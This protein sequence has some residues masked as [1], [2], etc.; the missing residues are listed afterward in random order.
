M[1]TL[2]NISLLLTA[3]IILISCD[4]VDAPRLP[5]ITDNNQPQKLK[6]ANSTAE[7]E[8]KIKSS[9]KT[10]YGQ[11]VESQYFLAS[12]E[13]SQS[14]AVS[15]STNIQEN[16]ID[17]ADRLKTDGNYLYFSKVNGAGI[18][19]IKANEKSTPLVSTLKINTLNNSILSGLYLLNDPKQLI[20]I[21]GDGQ[22]GASVWSNWFEPSYWQNRTTELFSIDVSDPL[23]PQQT[24][25]L[26]VDGQLISSRRIDN[27]LY[28]AT[29]Y[30]PHIDGLVNYPADASEVASN[31]QLIDASSLDSLLPQYR[32]NNQ[33][34]QPLF[35]AS[36]CFVT[37]TETSA[38]QQ[39]S[40]ISLLAIDLHN[41]Q[42]KPTGQCFSGDT[43]TV[44]ASSEA[45]YLATT[46]YSYSDNGNGLVYDGKP[47]T[48]IHKFSLADTTP[49]Y[50]GSGSVEGHLGWQQDLKAFRMSEHENVLRVITYVGQ[51][52]DSESSP[53]RLYTLA[54]NSTELTLDTLAQLPNETRPEP[55]GKVGEQI[56]ASRFIGDRGYLVTFRMTDPLYV[57][58]LSDPSDPFIASA[59]EI[60]GY[61][62]YL[63]P[64]GENFL[65]GIGKSAVA[66]TSEGDGR[67][68]W[69][70]GVKLSLIDV[71]DPT[72]P[73]EKQVINIGQRGTETAVSSTH[74]AFTSLLK[75]DTLQVALPVSLHETLDERLT[76]GIDIEQPWFTYQWT[77]N[78][79]H[80]LNIDT[81][82]GEITTL[83][84]VEGISV[85]PDPYYNWSWPY[86]RSALIGE[87]VYYL[88]EDEV[89]VQ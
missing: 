31:Q 77:R 76:Q 54:E 2:T 7:L 41:V 4:G 80:R 49:N 61:S 18:N 3:V 66:D 86:D 32:I 83:P 87:S 6:K 26:S 82:S 88:H 72:A 69:Y 68:A 56:Y 17:E 67:G 84:T 63:H 40:I 21:A 51:Q 34:S 13:D 33:E 89:A 23:T 44:Y 59:L 36:D 85:D 50:T 46:Q 74:H 81:V 52:S 39:S 15:S 29:R 53:A 37:D 75:G 79:L 70:Q 62:D 42:A 43:E 73:F 24:D 65:L 47:S 30:T 19:I 9:L 14:A 45:I 11:I 25:K 10:Q 20:A 38:Y 5:I 71:S 48:D 12:A 58:D 35:S 1:S 27:T 60:D 64:V 16:G 8:I 57:L 22:Y 78:E 28:I 55:L